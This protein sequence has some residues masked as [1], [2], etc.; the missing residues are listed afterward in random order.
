MLNPNLDEIQLNKQEYERYSRHLILPEVGLEGQ[1]R[2]KAASVLCVGTGGLGSPLLLYLAA[3]GVGRIGIVD[4]DVVDHSNLQRQVIHG[5]SW[6]GKP[7]IE[8][9]KN[10]ILEINPFCQVDLYETNVCS[11]NAIDIATPYD[12]IIDGTDN[13]PTRY[14]MNDVSVLLNKPNVYGSIFRF[15][16]QATVF[17]YE[18]GPNYRDLYPEPPPP[19]MV[20]SCAEGGV[21]GVLPGVIGCIQATEAIKIILGQ[22]TT[23]S[24]RLLLYNALDMTFRQLKL[25][26]N[27]VRPVIE[28]LIDYEQFCGIP[29]AKAEEAQ[30]QKLPEMTVTELKKLIDS[31]AKD[32]V[33]LDVRNPNEYQIAQIPGS[34]LVP[35]PDIEQGAG[36]AK[37]KE[38]L[39]GHRLIAHCKMGGR[40]AKALG[41]LKE[42]GIE[43]INVK[44][45]ITA[46][47]QEVDS[48]VPQY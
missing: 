30:Q 41:I 46:W 35:L 22:G 10:R 21:L 26:P 18:G 17:N 42:A 44:G 23:L 6:V 9:A 19:G 37:V 27:P 33:L 4:F 11:E 14:L 13:F 20:P 24:G 7:K 29:Q 1:K 5:T 43:G 31:G 2:L 47:S 28:K 15:E 16:G 8:S 3:A 45:G 12:I 40:S 32:F 48:S 25:R 38:L 39:N 36:V 34:V